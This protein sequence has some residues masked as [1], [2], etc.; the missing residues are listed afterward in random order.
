[1]LAVGTRYG[2]FGGGWYGADLSP[3][4]DCVVNA[5]GW[6][7]LCQSPYSRPNAERA[8]ARSYTAKCCS[9]S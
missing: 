5:P 3:S 2:A 8:V 4:V 7:L 1:M 9:I 6:V